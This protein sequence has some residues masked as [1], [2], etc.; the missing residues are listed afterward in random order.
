MLADSKSKVALSPSVVRYVNYIHEVVQNHME[1][2][3]ERF[4]SLSHLVLSSP[5]EFDAVGGC[6]PVV[7]VRCPQH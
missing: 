7:K 1:L 2:P 4:L 3:P 6:E 5:P